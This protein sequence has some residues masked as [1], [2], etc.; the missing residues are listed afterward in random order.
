MQ[1]VVALVSTH[2][3]LDI[4]LSNPGK[5]VMEVKNV[6]ESWE[7]FFWNPSIET[8]RQVSGLPGKITL[9]RE[10]PVPHPPLQ[11]LITGHSP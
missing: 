10:G 5:A 8:K 7:S 6:L 9:T 2:H 3:A 4:L 1:M 11:D